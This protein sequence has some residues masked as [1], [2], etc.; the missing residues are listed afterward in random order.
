MINC[1]NR[2]LNAQGIEEADDQMDDSFEPVSMET[3][4]DRPS[5]LLRMRILMV[6]DKE[7]NFSPTV[8][9]TTTLIQQAVT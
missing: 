1:M 2:L 5:H 7:C 8:L 3:L 6:E 9:E 4:K